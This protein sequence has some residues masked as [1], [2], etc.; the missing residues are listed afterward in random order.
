MNGSR[1]EN[2]RSAPCNGRSFTVPCQQAVISR[3]AEA[4]GHLTDNKG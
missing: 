2:A 1:Y 3:V 4:A